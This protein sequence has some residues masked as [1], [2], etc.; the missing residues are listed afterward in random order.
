M[1]AKKGQSRTG[2]CHRNPYREGVV[3]QSWFERNALI[4]YSAFK[5]G[6]LL[7]ARKEPFKV[8]IPQPKTAFICLTGP[9]NLYVESTPGDSMQVAYGIYG[10]ALENT[11]K[12]Q[13]KKLGQGKRFIKWSAAS[14]RNHNIWMN[15]RETPS[16]KSNENPP[17]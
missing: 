14:A 1:N 12:R 16:L 6:N 10:A 15:D 11:G 4:E 7:D 8:I 13:S 9:R 3:F 17:N 2:H 5:T